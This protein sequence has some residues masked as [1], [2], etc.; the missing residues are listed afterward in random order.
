MV[1]GYIVVDGLTGK[2]IEK[3]GDAFPRNRDYENKT[4]VPLIEN[5][6]PIKQEDTLLGTKQTEMVDNIPQKVQKTKEYETKNKVYKPTEVK[7]IADTKSNKVGRKAKETKA[8]EPTQQQIKE[9]I[10]GLM[11]LADMGDEDAM[12]TAEGLKLLL[13]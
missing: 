5:V 10:E 2:I 3:K 13:D 12:A 9:T 6:K 11:V 4:V 7:S 8:A 1:D